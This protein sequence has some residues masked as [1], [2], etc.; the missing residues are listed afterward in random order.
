MSPCGSVRG[1]HAVWRETGGKS[2]AVARLTRDF[3]H[4]LMPRQNMFDDG[5]AEA[6]TAG[7]S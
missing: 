2:T 4:S 6:G 7:L 5:Q 3:Q 1:Y